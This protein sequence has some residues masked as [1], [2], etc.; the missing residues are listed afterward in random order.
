[1]ALDASETLSRFRSP[2]GRFD[3]AQFD[4]SIGELL[5]SVTCGDRHARVYGEMV[6]LLWECGDVNGAMALES[7]WNDLSRQLDFS[8]YCSYRSMEGDDAREA[9]EAIC[10][11]HSGVAHRHGAS[12]GRTAS[13]DF[14]PQPAAAAAARR[15]LRSV[16]QEWGLESSTDVA[17]VVLT[18]LATNA[19]L[20]ARSPFQVVLSEGPSTTLRVSVH[21]HN[22]DLPRRYDSD[23]RA[24]SGR[25]LYLVEGL[26]A[27]WGCSVRSDGKEVW[28]EFEV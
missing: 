10:A 18:E 7:M 16:L 23:L 3:R 9:V 12:S 17:E 8:L 13:A 27:E 22:R 25:G 26:S 21:D 24:F 6:Q 5:R 11:L 14:E 2:G 4:G 20:H 1:M 19:V 28:A 15:F